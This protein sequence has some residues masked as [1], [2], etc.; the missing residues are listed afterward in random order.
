MAGVTKGFCAHPQITEAFLEGGVKYLAD[1]RIINLKRLKGFNI[2]KIMTRVSMISE[3]KDIVSYS[4]ISLN[5]ELET[6]KALSKVAT[7]LNKLHNIILMMDLGDLREG[8]YSESELYDSVT[9][10]IKLERIKLI[11]L[12]ANF[13]CYGGTIPNKKIL[14]KL[15]NI[16][17]KIEEKYKIKLKIISGGNSSSIYLLGKENITGINNLR[18]GESLILGT[19][20]AYGKQIEGTSPNGFILEAEIIEIKHKTSV[21][22]GEIGKD[23]FG[24]KPTFIDRGIR[25]RIICAIGKQDIDFDAIYPID[26]DLIILGGSSDHLIIDGE[27]SKVEYKVG[28]IFKF[29]IHYVSLLRSMTS[30]YIDKVFV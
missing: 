3:A 26:N 22:T 19:E 13:T 21:P 9:E 6:I 15:Y 14:D 11:G 10:I 17:L 24:K 2:T 20:S 5:S 30:E 23:A 27:N 18:L 16:A 12:G 29:N 4:D 8:Y 1:S 7:Q 28:D 25:K